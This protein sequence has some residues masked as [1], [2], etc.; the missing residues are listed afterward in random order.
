MFKVENRF[1]CCRTRYYSNVRPSV[2]QTVPAGIQGQ[3]AT[4][5]VN[6]IS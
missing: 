1:D 3:I 6:Y 5:K 2:P 4:N